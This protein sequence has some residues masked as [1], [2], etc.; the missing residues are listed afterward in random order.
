[1]E[2]VSDS[3]KFKILLE[4]N[5]IFE[6]GWFNSNELLQAEYKERIFNG[7]DIYFNIAFKPFKLQ[8]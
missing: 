8:Q 1:M 7:M 5:D 3:S 6:K 4:H 2:A